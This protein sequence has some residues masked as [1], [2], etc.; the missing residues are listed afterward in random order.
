LLRAILTL[1]AGLGAAFGVTETAG[2]Q[3][4][5]TI[6]CSTDDGGFSCFYTFHNAPKDLASCMRN[7]RPHGILGTAA[8]LRKDI[9]RAFLICDPQGQR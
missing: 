5:M 3:A 1:G 2:K 7:H 9:Q 6:T 8:A 4:T